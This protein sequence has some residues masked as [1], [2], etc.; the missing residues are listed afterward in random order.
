[1]LELLEYLAQC[2]KIK[3]WQSIDK[4]YY[5]HIIDTEICIL[6]AS[7]ILNSKIIFI[8][9]TLK[10]SW[11]STW[12]NILYSVQ[13][14]F[15]GCSIIIGQVKELAN[16]EIPCQNVNHSGKWL[17]FYNLPFDHLVIKASSLEKNKLIAMD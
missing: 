12:L 2:K 7:F 10:L 15:F 11:T 14:N 17:H 13:G 4:T 8:I 6:W 9:T 16:C 1:M 5:F 3:S